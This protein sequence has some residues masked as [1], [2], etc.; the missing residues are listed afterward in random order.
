MALNT[1]MLSTIIIFSVQALDP[2]QIEF[3]ES[4]VSKLQLKIKWNAKK[5]LSPDKFVLVMEQKVF[6]GTK[7]T[8]PVLIDDGKYKA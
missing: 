8:N 6:M 4:D 1:L 5:E 3:D 2:V 7:Y